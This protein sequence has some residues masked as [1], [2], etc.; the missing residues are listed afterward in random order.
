MV[1]AIIVITLIT[2]VEVI[3]IAISVVIALKIIIIIKI[4]NLGLTKAAVAT[5]ITTVIIEDNSAY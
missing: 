5:T 1:A 3:T 2:V 4:H